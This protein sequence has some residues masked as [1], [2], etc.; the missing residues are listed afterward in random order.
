MERILTD[1]EKIRRAESIYY[2]RNNIKNNYVHEKEGGIKEKIISNLL[3]MFNITL[4]IICVQNKDFIFSE[5]FLAN[6]NKYNISIKD[7]IVSFVGEFINSEENVDEIEEKNID[8]NNQDIKE[9]I[10]QNNEIYVENDS[11][12]LSEM[13][14]DINNLNA[15]YSFIKPINGTVTSHFGSRVSENKNVTGYHTGTDVAAPKGTIIKASMGGIVTLVSGD[16]DYGKH[17][18]IRCN[19]VT[20]LY[21]HCSKIYVE[22]GQIVA[23]GQ[24][25][26]EVGSTR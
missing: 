23:Q 12:S 25:I 10:V 6:I 20:T 13:E 17:F 7:K 3:I 5:K 15:C 4:L 9:E 24:A 22:E 11:S 14:L 18:K 1:N 16:G 21:A 8:E 2:R 26:A 19:N